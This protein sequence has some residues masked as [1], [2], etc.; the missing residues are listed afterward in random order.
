MH[1]ESRIRV[2]LV[3]ANVVSVSRLFV[4][5]I[6]FENIIC[7]A[8]LNKN[9]IGLFLRLVITS[10]SV[11]CV[12]NEKVGDGIIELNYKGAVMLT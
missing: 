12:A 8:N 3:T 10:R 11:T 2:T 9:Y 1:I 4:I 6:Y 7:K 5:V